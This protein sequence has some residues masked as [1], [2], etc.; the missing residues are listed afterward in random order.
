MSSRAYQTAF[1]AL[2]TTTLVAA[3]PSLAS[4]QGAVPS[5]APLQGIVIDEATYQPVEAAT[6]TLLGS[7]A[8]TTTGR[9]GTFAFAE[10]PLGPV[11]LQ[12]RAPGRPSMVQ[13]VVVSEGR[14]VFLQI[15]LPSVAAVLSELLVPTHG[16]GV[17]EEVGT[18]A[19]LLAIQV[20]RTR[21]SSGMVG[22]DDYTLNLRPSGTFQGVSAPMILI[23]G[24][25]M[26]LD[27]GAYAALQ[28][29]PASH[30]ERIE[31]LKG[32]AAVSRYPFAANGVIVVHTK[33]GG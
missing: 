23:D 21:V 18:A 15:L 32:P 33:R 13:E 2:L 25:V 30:V 14:V 11:S 28:R 24:V 6:V 26:S 5:D 10:A 7:D 20:P 3:G 22:K 4:A 17:D 1:V 29:I 9:W 27:D 8:E 31:V 16:T 12:V 19:D